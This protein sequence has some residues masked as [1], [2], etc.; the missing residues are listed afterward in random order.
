VKALLVFKFPEDAQDY[1][2][3]MNGTKYKFVIE[4][5]DDFLRSRVKYEDKN[6]IR[7]DEVRSKLNELIDERGL[8]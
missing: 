3:A 2:D 8:K 5:L 1:Q 4:E 7:C 6:Y